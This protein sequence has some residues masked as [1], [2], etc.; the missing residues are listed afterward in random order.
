MILAISGVPGVG[1]TKVATLLAKALD[2]KLVSITALVKAG[3]IPYT[4]DPARKT[5][6]LAIKDVQKAVN[7]I[8]SAR[9]ARAISKITG[10]ALRPPAIFIVEGH[11]AHLLKADVVFVLRCNPAVLRQRLQSRRW[12]R[13][14]VEENVQAELL[15]IITAEA[16]AKITRPHRI[17]KRAIYKAKL[18]E[19]DT[20]RKNPQATAATIA[21]ILKSA[22]YARK[23]RPGR[24]K[25]LK[26]EIF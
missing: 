10:A 16:L 8:T 1:K 6:V 19:I 14:K 25:W 2:A 15:D 3:K 18:Y 22:E 11:L 5:K 9:S 17:G 7:K 21:R 4:R 26:P 23:F 13:K 20:T 24:I 12:P